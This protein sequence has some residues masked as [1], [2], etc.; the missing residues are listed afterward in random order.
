MLIPHSKKTLKKESAVRSHE[1]FTSNSKIL[2]VL[3]ITSVSP[4]MPITEAKNI[5]GKC[6]SQFL[7]SIVRSIFGVFII[8]L[9]GEIKVSLAYEL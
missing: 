7:E 9:F 8:S 2:I 1:K 5:I 6:K 3:P 4:P